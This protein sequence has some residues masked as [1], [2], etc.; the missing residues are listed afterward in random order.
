VHGADILDLKPKVGMRVKI[1]LDESVLRKIVHYGHG[2]T[3][4]Q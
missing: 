3:M 4:F 1:M 2:V